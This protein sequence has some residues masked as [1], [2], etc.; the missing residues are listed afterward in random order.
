MVLRVKKKSRKY[1]GSRSWGVGN[2]K[3]ARGS[4]DRGGT[5][6]GGRKGKWTHTVVYEK[7]SIKKVGFAPWRKKNYSEINLGDISRNIEKLKKGNEIML[8][9]YKVLSR[10]SI[11]VPV[12]ISAR[13]FSK[14][15]EEK[16]K[17]V[18]GEAV[19]L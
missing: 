15:A 8:R 1:L 17:A 4:G 7:D 2:I 9:N 6:R 18:G 5:G 11:S 13:A 10:G 19:K 3:N 16:I 14:K 12:K